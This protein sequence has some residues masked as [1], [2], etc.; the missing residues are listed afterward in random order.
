MPD[1]KPSNDP[2]KNMRQAPA[3]PAY[4]RHRPM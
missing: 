1:K 2:W 3:E 4:D